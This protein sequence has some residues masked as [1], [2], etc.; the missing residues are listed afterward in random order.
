MILTCIFNRTCDSQMYFFKCIRESHALNIYI[1][2]FNK[3]SWNKTS[4]LQGGFNHKQ[5]SLQKELNLIFLAVKSNLK[6]W[7]N[8]ENSYIN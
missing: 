5:M 6:G 8:L 2:Q 1:Y 7:S 4:S 3:Q